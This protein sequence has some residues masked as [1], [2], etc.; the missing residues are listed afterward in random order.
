MATG[1]LN[2][3][4]KKKKK[5]QG[6]EN[7]LTD[8]KALETLILRIRLLMDMCG[9]KLPLGPFPLGYSEQWPNCFNFRIY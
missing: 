8:G 1:L 4:L 7:S 5:D 2:Q 6:S 9:R 3:K